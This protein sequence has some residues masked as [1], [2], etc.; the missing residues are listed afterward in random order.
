MSRDV[1]TSGESK[2]V[3]NASM[4]SAT[5]GSSLA[6]KK[7]VLQPTRANFILKQ[8]LRNCQSVE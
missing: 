3:Y 5:F 7:L 4:N 8:P 2:F 1:K 6:V